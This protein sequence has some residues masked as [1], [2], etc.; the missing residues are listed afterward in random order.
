MPSILIAST[1]EILREDL[2][3][4]LSPLFPLIIVEDA[5]QC[6]AAFR[7]AAPISLA[8]VGT[9]LD[10]PDTPLFEAIHKL[11]PTITVIAMSDAGDEEDGVD[12]V[13]RGA[14]GYIMPPLRK[15]DI[16]ALVGK[17]S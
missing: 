10:D 11:A 7:Q 15:D 6:L 1:D 4:I 3:Q 12:A 8:L 14:T 5:D 16:L 17:A 9:S 13:R 2:K